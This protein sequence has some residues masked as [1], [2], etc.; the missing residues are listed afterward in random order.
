MKMEGVG[1][2]G[3]GNVIHALHSLYSFTTSK[4]G[5]LMAV[6]AGSMLPPMRGESELV[7]RK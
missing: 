2:A 7:G 5:A 4:G 6:Q 3:Q 1:L